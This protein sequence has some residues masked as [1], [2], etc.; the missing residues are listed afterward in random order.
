MNSSS[1]SS[2]F[3]AL[4]VLLF[5][6]LFALV[7]RA[8]SPPDIPDRDFEGV[9]LG[10]PSSGEAPATQALQEAID[11]VAAEGGGRLI[12][13]EGS[14]LTGPLTLRSRVDLH[15]SEGA[16]LRFL[17]LS[18]KSAHDDRRYLSLLNAENLTDLRLSGEG[19]IDGQGEAWWQAFRYNILSLRRP[20]LILLNRCE[21]VEIAGLHFLNPPNC[22]LSLRL[23]RSVYLHDLELNAPDNSPNTDGINVSGRDYLIERCKVSTG[24]DNIVILTHSDPTWEAPVCRNFVIRDCTLG[25]G[26]GLSIGSYTDGGIRGVLVERCSFE[27]TTAGIRLKSSRGRGGLVEDLVYRDLTMKAVKNP[28]FISSYYPKTP[29]TPQADTSQP[30]DK[31]TPLWKNILIENL[32]AEAC[33]NSLVL[34][35]LPEAPIQD[36]TLKNVTLDAKESARIYFARKVRLENADLRASRGGPRFTLQDAEV[37]DIPQTPPETKLPPK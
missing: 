32:R 1:F 31:S 13:R 22:H 10:I 15:L 16:V 25:D 35:G 26:H 33:E 2:F 14:Y 6:V 11:K 29:K 3:F 30:V 36:L 9:L 24:D 5:L 12:L 8:V 4:R 23:C 19:T 28:I 34:W 18:A 20:Q 21:R 27:G 7:G 37:Q 17:P